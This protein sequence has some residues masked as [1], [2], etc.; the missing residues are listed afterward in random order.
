MDL[1]QVFDQELEQLGI[2][3]VQ[4]ETI[5]PRKSYKMNSSCADI[6]LF[7]SHKW[8]VTRPSLLFDTKDQIE[9]TTTNKFWLDVQLRYGDYDSHD[10][11]R[12]VRAKYLDYTTDSMSI[13][14][15]AT[16]LMVGIDLAYNLYSAYGQYFPGKSLRLNSFSELGM[17]ANQQFQVLRR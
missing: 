4:K 17:H 14:P 10:I 11:E 7:A 1:C 2:E 12:Y 16:G 5:H 3:T 6:L 9:A 13:Y 8:N 15:S